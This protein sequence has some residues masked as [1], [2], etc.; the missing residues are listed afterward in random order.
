VIPNAVSCCSSTCRAMLPRQGFSASCSA[1]SSNSVPDSRGRG[2]NHEARPRRT[3]PIGALRVVPTC[4]SRQLLPYLLSRARDT[5]AKVKSSGCTIMKG[6]SRSAT[7]PPWPC[8]RSHG[9]GIC[10]LAPSKVENPHAVRRPP[11]AGRT[12]VQ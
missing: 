3:I 6:R 2:F 12:R 7:S 5:A 9:A 4:H 11:S 8:R 10:A 1:L